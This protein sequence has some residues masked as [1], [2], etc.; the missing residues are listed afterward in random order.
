MEG[1]QSTE[2]VQPTNTFDDVPD[3]S[4]GASRSEEITGTTAI[5]NSV[6]IEGSEGTSP[7]SRPG[8][9]MILRE[10]HQAGDTLEVFDREELDD[11]SLQQIRSWMRQEKFTIPLDDGHVKLRWIYRPSENPEKRCVVMQRADPQRDN[12]L[13]NCRWLPA[14][15][16][17]YDTTDLSK[18]YREDLRD[19]GSTDCLPSW[20]PRPLI[21]SVWCHFLKEHTEVS[22]RIL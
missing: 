9:S 16:G 15:S 10:G 20:W 2:Y 18:L 6:G 17:T 14:R 13:R 1:V 5:R 11:E 7:G 3:A 19:S 22:R 4:S 21:D 8:S 12:K